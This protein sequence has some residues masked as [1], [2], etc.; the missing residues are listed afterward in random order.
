MPDNISLLTT[1]GSLLTVPVIEHVTR[2][3]KDVSLSII[4]DGAISD[5]AKEISRARIDRNYPYVDMIS[6]K[7]PKIPCY[8]VPNHNSDACLDLINHIRPA[9][10]LSAG[11]PRILKQPIIDSTSGVI[12]CHPGILPKYRGCTVLEWS[13]FNGDPVGATAHFMTTGIDEGPIILSEIMPVRYF[14]SYEMIRTRMISHQAS[15][16]ARALVHAMENHLNTRN[17]SVQTDG[18]YYDP[19]PYENLIEVKLKTGSG[20][21]HCNA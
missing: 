19:I 4:F 3:L 14:E 18:V 16:I 15:V 9:Y 11:T 8:F 7:F 10:L 6:G 13:I 1:V 2:N 17:I 20:Q 21:F 5:R 12:N